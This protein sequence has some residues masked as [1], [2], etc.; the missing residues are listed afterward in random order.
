[1]YQECNN[2]NEKDGDQSN[3]KDEESQVLTRGIEQQCLIRVEEIN[4]GICHINLV[5]NAH[6]NLLNSTALAAGVDLQLE[7]NLDISSQL[8]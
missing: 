2:E 4:F 7:M 5:T 3:G 6:K 1:M 8:F